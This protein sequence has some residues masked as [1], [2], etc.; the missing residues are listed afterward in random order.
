MVSKIAKLNFIWVPCIR[1]NSL[2]KLQRNIGFQSLTIVLWIPCILTIS[3]VK[4]SATVFAIKG[5]WRVMKWANLDKWFTATSIQSTP[6]DLD[7]PIMKPME[8]SSQMEFGMGSGC[9]KPSGDWVHTCEFGKLGKLPRI[10]VLLPSFLANKNLKPCDG[11]C[12]RLLS[13]RLEVWHEIQL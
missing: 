12:G 1:D 7:K 11:K 8:I 9:S 13:V 3:L 6:W 4:A 10:S 5:W 2:Q